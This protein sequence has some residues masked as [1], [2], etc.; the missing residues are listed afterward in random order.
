MLNAIV[1]RPFLLLPDHPLHTPPP[2]SIL[3]T[4]DQIVEADFGVAGN[5]TLCADDDEIAHD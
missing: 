1:I 5:V 4:H 2:N 3:L